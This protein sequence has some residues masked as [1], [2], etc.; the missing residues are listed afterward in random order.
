[1]LI[2]KITK[3]I[4]NKYIMITVV[5]PRRNVALKIRQ[6]GLYKNKIVRA[7]GNKR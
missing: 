4:R 2:Y 6:S 5:Y 7:A 1:M 3:H